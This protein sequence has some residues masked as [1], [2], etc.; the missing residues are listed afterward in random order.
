MSPSKFLDL[1]FE[2]ITAFFLV[3]MVVLTLLQV[4]SRYALH[5]AFEW[6]EELARLDLIFQKGYQST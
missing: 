1:I 4:V 2:G 6:T 5:A 3:S